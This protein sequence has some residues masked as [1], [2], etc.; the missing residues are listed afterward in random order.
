MAFVINKSAIHEYPNTVD[1]CSAIRV[2]DEKAVRA[3]TGRSIH[4]TKRT[5]PAAIR[6]TQSAPLC[7]AGTKSAI[8]KRSDARTPSSLLNS[9]STTH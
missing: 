6:C 8:P 3:R 7:L 4:H 2:F 9:R 1:R 5:A